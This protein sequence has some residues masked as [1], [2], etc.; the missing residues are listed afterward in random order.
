MFMHSDCVVEDPQ[1][2]IE[3]GRSLLALRDK[4]VKMVGAKNH[5]KSSTLENRLNDIILHDD[6]LPLFCVL[7]H[8]ELFSH[9]GGFIG[10]YPGFE[11]E[12]LAHRMQYYGYKQAI[13][14]NSYI[15]HKGGVTYN[16]L[17]KENPHLQQTIDASRDRVITDLQKLFSR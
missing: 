6:F 9:I 8:R 16:S 10:D 13:C 5:T 7:C 3:M 1:W 2:M 4:N 11:D 12:E 14:G 15:N 17:I